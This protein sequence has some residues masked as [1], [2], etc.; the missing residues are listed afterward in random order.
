MGVI[1]RIAWGS[2]I[3]LR[4]ETFL[5]IFIFRIFRFFKENGFIVS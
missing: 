2:I 5:F 3:V 1:L 4:R